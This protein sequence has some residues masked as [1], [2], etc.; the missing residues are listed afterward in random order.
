MR[1]VIFEGTRRQEDA[2]AIR[3]VLAARCPRAERIELTIARVCRPELLLV[4]SAKSLSGP[5]PPLVG[6]S[7]DHFLCYDT[8]GGRTRVNHVKIDDEFGTIIVDVKRPVRLCV[9]VDK[10]GEG[11]VDPT[12]SLLCYQVRLDL[13]VEPVRKAEY[14]F[15]QRRHAHGLQQKWIV[16]PP[17]PEPEPQ[18]EEKPKRKP[19]PK[20]KAPA[21]KKEEEA[22]T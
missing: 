3:A 17:A 9:P 14:V 18:A 19:A 11:V 10:N 2:P 12:A 5:P 15:L 4:P 20:R 1:F 22:T 6:S 21:K 8:K 16:A 13:G 7:L